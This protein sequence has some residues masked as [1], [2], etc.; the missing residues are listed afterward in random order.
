MAALARVGDLLALLG[1]CLGAG[2]WGSIDRPRRLMTLFLGA[3]AAC[4]LGQAALKEAG[5]GT[6]AFGNLWDLSLLLLLLPALQSGMRHHLRTTIEPLRWVAVAVWCTLCLALGRLPEFNDA[7]SIGYY[8]LVAACG[9]FLVFQCVDGT[10]PL[11]RER[12]FVWGSTI[13]T[14]GCLD[15]LTTLAISRPGVLP[16]MTLIRLMVARNAAWCGAYG[17]LAYSLILRGRSRE[18][19]RALHGRGDDVQRDGPTT[20]TR[21]LAARLRGGEPE[22]ALR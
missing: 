9:A 18:S 3:S 2:L 7:A 12:C 1:F 5:L 11:L 16:D 4:G 6:G 17:F 15:A 14:M 8:G 22:T 20:R 19:E 21:Q 10:G 13:L